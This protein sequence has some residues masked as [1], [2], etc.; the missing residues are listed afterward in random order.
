MERKLDISAISFDD[1]LGDG[2]QSTET[3]ETTPE[4]LDVDDTD[5]DYPE[6]IT[7]DSDIEDEGNEVEYDEEDESSDEESS[8]DEYEDEV[9]GEEEY[10][11]N[12]VGQIASVLGFELDG[13]YEETVDG[14]TNFVRDISQQAAEDQLQALFE[15]YPEVQKHLDY[16]MT[17]GSSEQFLQANNPQTDYASIELD[18]ES[19]DMQRAVMGQYLLAKGHDREFVMEMVDT[20]ESNGKLYNKSLSARDELAQ[21]QEQYRQQMLEAQRAEYEAQKQ[22]EEAFWND[23]AETIE[24]ENNFAGITIPDRSKAEFFDYISA[25]VGPNGET[26]RDLDMM[27]LDLETRIAMDY[28]AFSG[29]DLNG[30]IDKKA[31][32]KSA[33]SLREKIISNEDRIKS[34]RKA[35]RSKKFDVDNLDMSALLG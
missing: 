35:T 27:E 8:D 29:F 11:D 9:E 3:E 21:A 12:I 30:I 1:M 16:V 32:T 33:Q 17:G 22:Q 20:L 5:D 34:A 10:S 19:V 18:E 15:Q 2:L 13:E 31:R 24:S 25:P 28:L 7:N 4:S 14:L 26:Q 6:D 23:I